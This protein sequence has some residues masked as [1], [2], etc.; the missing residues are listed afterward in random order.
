MVGQFAESQKNPTLQRPGQ[1][2]LLACQNPPSAASVAAEQ[3]GKGLLIKGLRSPW[4][5]GVPIGCSGSH[6]PASPCQVVGCWHSLCGLCR[7]NPSTRQP[8]GIPTRGA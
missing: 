5:G 6:G 7:L 4:E 1:P 8:R 3:W 2:L